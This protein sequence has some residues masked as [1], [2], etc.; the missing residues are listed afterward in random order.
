MQI[1][2]QSQIYRS[3]DLARGSEIYV[4]SSKPRNSFLL[5]SCSVVSDFVTPWTAACQASLSFT[6]LLELA[7]TYVHWVGDATNHL[8]LCLTVDLQYWCFRCTT[9]YS[10]IFEILLHKRFT[11]CL[12]IVTYLSQY[13]LMVNYFVLWII[14]QCYIFLLFKFSLFPAPALESLG[15]LFFFLIL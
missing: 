10:V 7:Q 15:F 14:I 9:K 12:Y 11:Y 4:L 2:A 5:F 1:S 8:I 6:N 3:H 13:K